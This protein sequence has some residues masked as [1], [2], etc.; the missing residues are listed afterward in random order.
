MK[1]EG[2]GAGG[3]MRQA[4]ACDSQLATRDGGGVYGE[5][6][7]RGLP[8]GQLRNSDCSVSQCLLV[9]LVLLVLLIPPTN[10]S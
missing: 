6:C 9:V 7:E 1:A 2:S 5:A 3:S 8:V 4:A 10:N